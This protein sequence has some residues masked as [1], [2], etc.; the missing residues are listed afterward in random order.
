MCRC[1]DPVVW[2]TPY[3]D[4][5]N[6]QQCG[7]EEERTCAGTTWITLSSATTLVCC[8]ACSPL[9]DRCA[10]SFS[11]LSAW[12]RR[13]CATN[14]AA[15]A[16]TATISNIDTLPKHLQPSLL[17]RLHRCSLRTPAATLEFP[18]SV[19]QPSS[20]WISNVC[21]EERS[22][23]KSASPLLLCVIGSH[24]TKRW[25]SSSTSIAADDLG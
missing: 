20:S 1:T 3:H 21:R 2:R 18:F 11:A 9:F 24:T 12:R 23:S 19:V 13:R 16:T 25:K 5:H 22:H 14:T 10:S 15:S 8:A 7:K 6:G 17:L 4:A